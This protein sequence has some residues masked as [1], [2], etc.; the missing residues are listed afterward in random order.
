MITFPP[1]ERTGKESAV[2]ELHSSLCGREFLAYNARQSYLL[3]KVLVYLH[4]KQHHLLAPSDWQVTAQ[5]GK[6]EKALR[7]RSRENWNGTHRDPHKSE[8]LDPV[9][10][11]RN[12]QLHRT[13]PKR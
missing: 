7:P 5:Q 9:I 12:A 1:C 13:S 2:Q 11:K 4:A 10:V 6:K 3:E 8:H